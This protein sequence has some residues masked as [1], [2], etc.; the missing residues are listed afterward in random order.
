MKIK[1][2]KTIIKREDEI[3]ELFTYQPQN[4]YM[5]RR[6]GNIN[7]VI[8]YLINRLSISP[9][10]RLLTVSDTIF[11][12]ERIFQYEDNKP[13][14]IRYLNFEFQYA[15]FTGKRYC[16]KCTHYKKHYCDF[17]EQKL[18]YDYYPN[19]FGYFEK[20]IINLDIQ[21][22]KKIELFQE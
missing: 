5:E 21:K 6:Q 7:Y 14:P 2:E 18:E 13:I 11:T 9:H 22:L 17:K 8:F 12:H 3:Q 19:C 10:Y 15:P 20:S 16:R 1:I 4:R